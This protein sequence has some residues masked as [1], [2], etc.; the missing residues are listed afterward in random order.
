MKVKIGQLAKLTDTQVVTIRYYEK[1]GLLSEPE[2]TGSN[3]RLYNGADIERLQFI[4]HCRRHGMG[5]GEI[6]E[7]LAYRDKPMTDCVWIA[8]MI[9]THIKN[10]EEQMASLAHLKTH[11]EALRQSCSGVHSGESCGIIQSLG[12]WEPCQHCGRPGRALEGGK[13]GHAAQ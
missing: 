6:R 10:V 12:D 4:R 3:Y 7:L 9:E 13:A 1:E 8:K 11:L 5:L 2:R